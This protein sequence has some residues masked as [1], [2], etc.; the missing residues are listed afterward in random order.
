MLSP[1]GPCELAPRPPDGP[2]G[3]P[4]CS[5]NPSVMNAYVVA[6][7]VVR[8]P[9]A[10]FVDQHFDSDFN[11][12]ALE[13]DP[14]IPNMVS[15]Q[16]CPRMLPCC[17][18]WPHVLYPG[19]T[20]CPLYGVLSIGITCYAGAQ[21]HVLYLG[22]SSLISTEFHVCPVAAEL[23]MVCTTLMALGSLIVRHTIHSS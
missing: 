15:P 19:A 8:C 9:Q 7:F 21:C 3:M 17:L 20:C 5:L 11:F 18:A 2:H 6:S 4:V 12:C 14:V 23:M 1:G 13:E 10:A 16:P 22:S